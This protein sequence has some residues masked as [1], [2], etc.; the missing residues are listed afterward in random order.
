MII[1]FTVENFLS[2]KESQTLSLVA[3]PPY[4]I[5]NDHI[6][7]TPDN[8]IKLLKV[9]VIYGANAS[10]KSN[11]LTAIDYLKHL[12]TTSNKNSVS[13]SFTFTPFLLDKNYKTS[14]T[15]F[16]INF[17]CNNIRYNYNVCLDNEKIYS[18]SLSSYPKKQKRNV[19]N[20]K[21]EG[22]KYTFKAGVD[23]KP[24]KF[25]ED[26]ADK[27]LKNVLYLS[28]AVNENGNELLPIYQ[29]FAKNLSQESSINEVA[30]KVHE[31]INYRTQLIDFFTQND[32]NIVD[33][34]VNKKSIAEA[35]VKDKDIPPEIKDKI[36]EKHKDDFF[37]KIQ[38]IHKD[39]DNDIIPFDFGLESR[40]T[41]KLFSLSSLIAKNSENKTFYVDEL[42]A[43]L[44]PLLVKSFVNIFQKTSSNQLIC[45]T[46]DTHLINQDNLRKD[47]IYFVEKDPEQ[48]TQLYSLLEFKVRNDRENWESRYLSGRYG[49]TPS[50]FNF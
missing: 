25:Y 35:I 34:K 36:I 28:K 15:F 38:T 22:D 29:W 31:D 48:S 50:V 8:N 13:D 18:E 12:V 20:R 11:F 39:C 43:D 37:Y 23:L 44:H 46:H 27:T 3:Q 19:F 33:L 9:V 21:L 30:E 5:H 2:F 24:K 17:F 14:P 26:I 10:G 45:V 6:L 16:D 4:D 1:D 41:H 49:A 40:G 32:I 42:S 47:Q 7:N